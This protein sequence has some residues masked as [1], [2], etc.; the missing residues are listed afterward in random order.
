MWV[1]V[2]KTFPVYIL[3]ITKLQFMARFVYLYFQIQT[4]PAPIHQHP[5]AATSNTHTATHSTDINTHKL[6]FT[7]PPDALNKSKCATV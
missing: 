7:I 4:T 6:A 2:N 3:K 1:K 5:Q